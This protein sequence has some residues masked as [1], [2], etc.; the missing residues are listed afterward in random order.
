MAEQIQVWK[1]N[2]GTFWKS[3]SQALAYE[4]R[5]YLINLGKSAQ[6]I[7]IDTA[8]GTIDEAGMNA[9]AAFALSALSATS[10]SLSTAVATEVSPG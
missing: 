1:A 2:D 9:L 6:S 10:A 8:T 3:E 5:L 7:G 4:M